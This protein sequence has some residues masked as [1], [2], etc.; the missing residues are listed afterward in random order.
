MC[1][2]GSRASRRATASQ[3]RASNSPSATRVQLAALDAVH[4]RGEFLGVEARRGHP[5]V[6]QPLGGLG[7]LGEQQVIASR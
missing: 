2:S 4:V 3:K 7:H 6:G 5:G 1:C